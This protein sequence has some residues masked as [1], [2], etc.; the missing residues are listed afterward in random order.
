MIAPYEALAPPALTR[1]NR[2]LRTETLSLYYSLNRFHFTVPFPGGR[3]AFERWCRAM[4]PHFPHVTRSLSFTHASG[5]VGPRTPFY[6]R[7]G[8]ALSAERDP[9]DPRRVVVS[10]VD[11]EY[12]LSR[13]CF[14]TMLDQA[15]PFYYVVGGREGFEDMV[16][17]LCAVA[18]LCTRVNSRIYFSWS[19]PYLSRL[20]IT[21]SS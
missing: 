15:G 9:D 19:I 3:P 16:E 11:D 18:P 8:F 5:T 12:A 10:D 13:A 1:T 2:Q 21:A 6:Y 7:V 14:R 20:G 4:A 17:M